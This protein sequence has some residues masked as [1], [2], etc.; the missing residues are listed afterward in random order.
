MASP[1]TLL[2]LA[3]AK[4]S[5]PRFSEAALVIIDA[6]GEYRTGRLPLAGIEAAVEVLA[7][8]LDRARRA[9]GPIIHV[10]HR[11]KPGGLFDPETESGRILPELA[12]RAGERVVEKT[13]PNAFAATDLDAHL[14]G[15]GRPPLIVS[16][17]MTHMCVSSTVRAALDLGHVTSVVRDAVATRDLPGASA[18]EIVSAAVLNAA[19]LAALAD[20]FATVLDSSSLE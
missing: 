1:Q 7:G 13:L 6:Q 5:V 14:S 2:Q 8:L 17:F 3:G 20:R 4:P 11:G 12:P 16:G 19:T 18:A 15:L 10:V 9:G